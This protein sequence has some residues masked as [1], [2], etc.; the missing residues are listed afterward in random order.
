MVRVPQHA[1]KDYPDP[2]QR[3]DHY[4]HGKHLAC[5]ARTPQGFGRRDGRVNRVGTKKYARREFSCYLFLRLNTAYARSL[6]TRSGRRP[7]T[8]LHDRTDA[9]RGNTT[10][11]TTRGVTRRPQAHTQRSIRP[12]K[13]RSRRRGGA[14][15]CNINLNHATRG[16]C[17]VRCATRFKASMMLTALPTIDL[18][19]RRY[20]RTTAGI[21]TQ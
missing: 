1:R 5:S 11:M 8:L 12:S 10:I 16:C 7:A 17:W 15:L 6:V 2:N 3:Y 4:L 13:R 9:T 19:I 21:P 20:R 18:I 14:R